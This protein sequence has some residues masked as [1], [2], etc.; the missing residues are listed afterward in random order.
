MLDVGGGQGG[1]A[2]GS[3]EETKWELEEGESRVAVNKL[4][5]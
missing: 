2:A 4:L 3:E 1:A 5:W